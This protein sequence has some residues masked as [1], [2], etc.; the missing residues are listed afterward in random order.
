MKK[1]KVLFICIHN[2]ARSQ[3]AEAF[4]N[5]LAPD[6]FEAESA[7]LEP[8]T[9]N[10]MVVEVMQQVGIDI[11]KNKT[12]SVYDFYKQGRKYDYVIT[13][14]DAASSKQCPVFPGATKMLNWNFTDPSKLSNLQGII[15][16]R[17]QIKEKIEEFIT[18]DNPNRKT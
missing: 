1:Q 8:G 6:K 10:P 3:M 12:K 13:V 16:I 4:L 9:L 18:S 2:S 5:S 15:E 11:S 7:G 14:C 17:D